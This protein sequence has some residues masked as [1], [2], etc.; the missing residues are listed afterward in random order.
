MERNLFPLILPLLS[1][2]FL[3]QRGR[4]NSSRRRRFRVIF[5][6]LG[7][8]NARIRRRGESETAP[9]ISNRVIDLDLFPFPSIRT[10]KKIVSPPKGN[11]INKTV[12]NKSV[13]FRSISDRDNNWQNYYTQWNER[14]Q[15]EKEGFLS[16]TDNSC[17]RAVQEL[18]ERLAQ[19]ENG[20]N[21]WW[22]S[23][24]C[25]D[26]VIFPPRPFL[27]RSFLFFPR[28]LPLRFRPNPFFH[29]EFD[30]GGYVA[31]HVSRMYTLKIYTAIKSASKDGNK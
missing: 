3:T 17:S 21:G 22:R 30:R 1:L 25:D 18:L 10:S 4:K 6:S 13:I 23:A 31:S 19:G 2:F 5:G 7:I 24:V 28:F 14:V 9:G 29:L 16:K 11:L 27:F 26:P 12:R 8:W 20:K 15:Q